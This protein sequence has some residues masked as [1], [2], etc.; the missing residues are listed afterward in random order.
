MSSEIGQGSTF[1]S[2]L[3]CPIGNKQKN[4]E[5]EKQKVDQSQIFKDLKIL[6]VGGFSQGTDI[7]GKLL[8]EWGMKPE[9]IND[10]SAAKEF[11]IHLNKQK[12]IDCPL[13]L[14]CETVGDETIQSLLSIMNARRKT[15]QIKTLVLNN[16]DTTGLEQ[17]YRQLGINGFIKKPFTSAAIKQF[18]ID[19][20]KTDSFV[21]G[22]YQLTEQ[23]SVEE[24]AIQM[25]V[26]LAEDNVINQMV[27]KTL[28]MK[29]GC[30]VDIV[31][32]GQL[33]VDA[34]QKNDY[35]AIFMDCQM[36]VMDGYEATEMIREQEEHD[37]HIPVIALTA[38]AMD[39]EEENCYAAGMDKYLTKPINI[40]HLVQTLQDLSE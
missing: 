10:V 35:D 23:V 32:N 39:G 19:V 24:K 15:A 18:I 12:G 6:I 22:R 17:R 27:A 31:E 3:T 7:L 25:H 1:W 21:S 34:W 30:T 40:A 16:E 29:S 13:V 28:L 2:Q 5:Q 9:I 26:L 11:L 14:F 36:P 37:Q 38:N 4:V 8:T 20:L 33:A